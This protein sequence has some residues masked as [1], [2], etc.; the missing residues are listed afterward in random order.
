M[1]CKSFKPFKL[2]KV[3]SWEDEE[4]LLVRAPMGHELH[5]KLK[6]VSKAT[7]IGTPKLVTLC[8]DYALNNIDYIT[9]Y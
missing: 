3:K 2:L 9:K 8:V 7:G 1:S 6:A 5:E 4:N